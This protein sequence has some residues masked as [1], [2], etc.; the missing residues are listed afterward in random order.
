MN[1]VIPLEGRV[2]TIIRSSFVAAKRVTETQYDLS[3]EQFQMTGVTS[4][5]ILILPD[6]ALIEEGQALT[7]DMLLR[8][9]PLESFVTVSAEEALPNAL[10][11]LLRLAIADGRLTDEELLSIQPALEGRVWKPGLAVLVGD[12]YSYGSFLWR[13]L[14]AHTTQNDWPPDVVPA[15]WRKVEIIHEDE[16][17]VWQVGVDYALGD[18]VAYPDADGSFFVCLQAHTSQTG[19]EPPNVPALWKAKEDAAPM[20][21]LPHSEVESDA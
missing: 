1:I 10:G 17:R 15:L 11:L 20:N 9:L 19:W 21:E 16:A 14:Q 4:D 6:D 7:D 3:G 8:A 2:R 12:V 18:E 13:C 5:Q